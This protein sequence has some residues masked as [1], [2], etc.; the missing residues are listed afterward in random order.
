MMDTVLNLGM[1]DATVE[2]LA[3]KSG[4]PASLGTATAVSYRCTATWFSA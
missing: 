4:N 2:S 1:N 3:E